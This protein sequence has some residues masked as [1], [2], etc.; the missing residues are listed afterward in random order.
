MKF[1]TALFCIA[2]VSSTSLFTTTALP[3]KSI[4]TNDMKASSPISRSSYK[5]W[6]NCPDNDDIQS[7]LPIGELD[8]TVDKKQ[9]DP[10]QDIAETND[11]PLI[12]TNRHIHSGN[13][14]SLFTKERSGNQRSWFSNYLCGLQGYNSDYASDDIETPAFVFDED[15]AFVNDEDDSIMS[16]KGKTI[17]NDEF[18]EAFDLSDAE[19]DT[20]SDETTEDMAL[21]FME[22]FPK[23]KHHRHAQFNI[24]EGALVIGYRG[25]SAPRGVWYNDPTIYFPDM[26]FDPI[27]AQNYMLGSG[28]YITDKIELAFTYATLHTRPDMIPIVCKLYTMDAENWKTIPK[29]WI[30]NDKAYYHAHGEENRQSISKNASIMFSTF[31]VKPSITSEDPYQLAIPLHM[32][33]GAK[34]QKSCVHAPDVRRVKDPRSSFVNMAQKWN[35]QGPI[36]YY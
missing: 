12:E 36:P 27:K 24:P 13:Y 30:P 28:Y 29:V 6:L 7:H 9:S 14:R 1:S 3:T 22:F 5:P 31:E 21:S 26:T 2:A 34:L 4:D 10:V 19:D 25:T 23:K 15:D 18:D 33:E 20:D 32:F 16:I 35:I 8:I 17:Q 11:Q